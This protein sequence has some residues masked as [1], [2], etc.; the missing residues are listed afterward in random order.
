MKRILIFIAAAIFASANGNANGLL[1]TNTD[2]PKED[3]VLSFGKGTSALS[4]GYGFPNLGKTGASLLK[5]VLESSGYNTGIRINNKLGPIHFRYEYGLN[6]EI[7]LGASVN[8]SEYEM[9][10]T[11]TR[12]IGTAGP[13]TFDDKIT[14]TSLSVLLRMQ[15]HFE[16]SDKWD[17]YFGFGLGY[18][19]VI[20]KF[21]TTDGLGLLNIDVP[22]GFP[23]GFE[24]TLGTRYYF[25]K[26][27]GAYAELGIAK[28]LIQFGLAGKF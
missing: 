26:N 28:S 6:P 15:F 10:F 3:K 16:T 11:H 2:S 23:V 19:N 4:A 13:H 22:A 17:P 24:S 9:H 18:R 1:E 7:G 14:R 20:Y 21:E 5:E 12:D 8:Y 25:T 27:F